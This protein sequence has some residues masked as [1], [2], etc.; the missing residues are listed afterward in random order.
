MSR[1]AS[2]FLY[3][4]SLADRWL[5]SSCRLDTVHL[6]YRDIASTV[7]LGEWM[8]VWDC[9]KYN[10]V[11][12]LIM[13]CGHFLLFD[14]QRPTI[15]RFIVA[16]SCSVLIIWSFYPFLWAWDWGLSVVF[17]SFACGAMMMPLPL[18][19]CISELARCLYVIVCPAGFHVQTIWICIY[20][21]WDYFEEDPIRAIQLGVSLQLWPS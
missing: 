21:K 20:D 14:I 11:V 4:L 12:Q 7:S 15:F 2:Y 9:L 19:F 5:E 17:L 18:W 10:W 16:V 1:A 13:G 3:S 6:Q 8:P